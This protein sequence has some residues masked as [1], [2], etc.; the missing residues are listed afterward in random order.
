MQKESE[1]KI[2]KQLFKEILN[3]YKKLMENTSESAELPCQDNMVEDV[4][5]CFRIM[6]QIVD[7]FLQGYHD[8]KNQYKL[9]EDQ[10]I[11]KESEARKH[12]QIQ[13]QLKIYAEDLQDTCEE[14]QKQLEKSNSQIIQ[15]S[16]EIVRMKKQI[17]ISSQE[18]LMTD[19]TQDRLSTII[20]QQK[21]QVQPK[22]MIKL[23]KK[24]TSQN[25]K[26]SISVLGQTITID[27]MQELA[28]LY[29]KKKPK[30]AIKTRS[31]TI[32]ITDQMTK[33]VKQKRMQSIH[34][35]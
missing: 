6:C 24:K 31:N 27:R 23:P 29:G 32:H 30:S 4:Q 33:P 20:S 14:M 9:L 2:I 21:Q 3:Y 13:Q 35:V 19:T 5:V 11:Q 1:E 8:L 10:L 12:I 18:R 34:D 22:T 15:L 16:K 28:S 26:N 25:L 7:S 17:K